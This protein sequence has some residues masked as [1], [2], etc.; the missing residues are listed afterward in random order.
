MLIFE[1]ISAIYVVYSWF[2]LSWKSK[3]MKHNLVA[4]VKVPVELAKWKRRLQLLSFLGVL[5]TLLL[6]LIVV[7]PAPEMTRKVR[8]SYDMIL[9][10]GVSLVT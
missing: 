6:M 3:N 2:K 9:V 10:R 7:R 5:S 1:S 8:W 4:G